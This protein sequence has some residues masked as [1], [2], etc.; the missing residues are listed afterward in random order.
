MGVALSALALWSCERAEK[1]TFQGSSQER[2][3]VGRVLLHPSQS[4]LERHLDAYKYQDEEG[5]LKTHLQGTRQ[6]PW[7]EEAFE[8][9]L[10]EVAKKRSAQGCARAKALSSDTESFEALDEEAQLMTQT[11]R[12]V[13]EQE[14]RADCMDYA[15]AV[16]RS[17]LEGSSLWQS[18]FQDYTVEKMYEDGEVVTAYIEV[19]DQGGNPRRATAKLQRVEDGSWRVVGLIDVRDGM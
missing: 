19:H 7:C 2:A 8:R 12:F 4:V 6:T 18:S 11:L 16:Y 15:R 1:V 17:T 3:R 9:V 10:R 5:A 14:G 13:C